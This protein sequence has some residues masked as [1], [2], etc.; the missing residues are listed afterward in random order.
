MLLRYLVLYS[1]VASPVG[2]IPTLERVINSSSIR[3][4]QLGTPQQGG[5]RKKKQK[6]NIKINQ[7]KYKLYKKLVDKNLI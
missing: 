5:G 1:P 3:L 7:M 4:E 6:G 2:N